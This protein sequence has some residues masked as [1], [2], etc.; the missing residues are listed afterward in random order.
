[1][2]TPIRLLVIVGTR[3]EAIKLIPI[4]KAARERGELFSVC[5]CSSGQ[6][7]DLLDSVWQD[8]QISPDVDL[9][10]MQE[11]QRPT[12]VLARILSS[13]GPHVD[14]FFPNCI[15]VQGDTMTTLAASLVGYYRRIPVA[16]VEAGLRS[17]DQQNPWPEETN[18][19]LVSRLANFHFAPTTAA[20]ENLLE[21]GYSSER[22][23]VTGNTGID[24][25]FLALNQH[26]DLKS[27][28]PQA[29]SPTLLLTCHRRESFG[30]PMESI[31]Q[32]ILRL[33]QTFPTLKVFCPVH[34]NP[35]VS[36]VVS[37]ML[38]NH[39]R[40]ELSPPL[41]YLPFLAAMIRS[42]IILTDSGGV[43]EEAPSL[44]RPVLVLRKKT[45][46]MEA[47]ESGNAKL[48]GTNSEEIFEAAKSLLENTTI[49]EKMSHAQNPFG[50]GQAA[51]R[52]LEIL[53]QELA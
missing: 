18:R 15:L 42:T 2:T 47:V 20:W 28:Q 48:V 34:P 8:F 5:F 24:A 35:A 40:V 46:R 51:Y 44:G 37:G 26:P 17:F 52:I 33:L 32:G 41:G 53:Q 22:C 13:L 3:P 16:H 50:D 21:E 39:T 19:V 27:I 11:R 36:Q 31:C 45:E 43:Q 6:H 1:M 7:Q 30:Q 25:L 4:V 12:E 38:G 10:T 23:W 49:Y 9:H 14:S 29:A